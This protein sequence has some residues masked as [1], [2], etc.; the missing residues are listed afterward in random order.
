MEIK[1]LTIE[2]TIGYKD[3]EGVEHKSVTFGRRVD[4]DFVFA[5]DSSP[6]SYSAT[7]YNDLILRRT[8]TQFGSLPIPVPIEV[9]LSL[10][11]VDREDLYDAER[12]FTLQ[13]LNGRKGEILSH[14][15]AKLAI[16]Y[17]SNGIVYD[18]VNFGRRI[19]GY[20][21]VEADNLEYTGI[22]RICFLAGK[23][24]SQL[25]QSNGTATLDSPI[26][27]DVIGKLDAVDLETLRN[28]SEVWRNSFRGIREGIQRKESVEHSEAGAGNRVDGER[29]SSPL[30]RET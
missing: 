27:L 6:L 1:P 9:L 8:I 4:G 19:T 3:G 17:E 12:K 5:L 10:D 15:K 7:Q 2:L 21:S 30:G 20:D 28:A 24:I 18:V 23:Q 14:D 22:R 16:G 29:D 26:G 13:Y 25:S 11:S